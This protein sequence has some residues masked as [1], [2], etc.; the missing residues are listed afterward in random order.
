MGFKCSGMFVNKVIQ[1][2]SIRELNTIRFYTLTIANS[3]KEI[4]TINMKTKTTLTGL[5]ILLALACT[6]PLDTY[7]QGEGKP[8]GPPPW[9]PAHGYRAKTRHVYFP[10]HNFYFDVQ[11]NVYIFMSGD[12]WQV[13]VK[14]PSLYAGI[15]LKGAAKVELELDTDSPQKH[16]SDHIVKYKAKDEGGQVKVKVKTGGPGK[17]KG[18]KK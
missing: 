11:K 2:I 17:G 1:E 15:D 8:K 14:L 5:A 13:G 7:G 18:K 6:I 16:N 10:D 12:N 3:K 9:A 4:K